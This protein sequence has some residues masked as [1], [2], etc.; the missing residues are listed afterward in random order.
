MSKEERYAISLIERK[1]YQKADGKYVCP[2]LWKKGEP[3]LPNNYRYAEKRHQN[4]DQ[5][6]VMKV[7]ENRAQINKQ[8]QDW[9]DKGYVREVP[10]EERRPKTAFYLPIFAVIKPDRDTT[11]VGLLLMAEQRSITRA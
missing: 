9:L 7:P 6:K 4:F 2:V 5:G 8:V 1:I 11:K 10:K 3:D